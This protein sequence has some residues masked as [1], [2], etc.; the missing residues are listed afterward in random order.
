MFKSSSCRSC[1]YYQLTGRRGGMCQLLTVPVMGS[2]RACSC[3]DLPF[4]ANRNSPAPI[5]KQPKPELITVV[6]IPT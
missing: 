3:S 2:W 6:G 1:R 5:V 4:E